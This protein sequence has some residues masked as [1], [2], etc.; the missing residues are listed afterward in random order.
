VIQEL[1]LKVCDPTLAD[2]ARIAFGDVQGDG[3]PRSDSDAAE[4]YF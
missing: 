2:G 1:T 4:A 3:L